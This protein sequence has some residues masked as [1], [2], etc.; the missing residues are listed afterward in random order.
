M[1]NICIVVMYTDNY[2]KMASITVEN[3]I[4]LY[5]NLHNYGLYIDQYK[6]V[7]S[8]RSF[9]WHK[10]KLCKELLLT[11]KYEWLF[12]LDIDCLIMNSSIRLESFIDE[13]YSYILPSHCMPAQDTPITTV[14]GVQNIISSQ[15]FVRNNE[16][17]IAILNAIWDANNGIDINEFDHEGRATRIVINSEQFKDDIKIIEEH[18]LNRFW[19]FNNP[20][21]LNHFKGINDHVWQPGDFIVH[22]TGYPVDERTK[23]LSDLNYFSDIHISK[24]DRAYIL[25]ANDKYFDIVTMC[26]R[27]IRQSSDVHIIIYMLNSNKIVDVPNSTTIN[28][29]CNIGEND[30]KMYSEDENFYIEREHDNIYN[31]LI[32]RPSITKDALQKYANT[33]VYVDSDIIVTQYIDTIFDMYDVNTPYPFVTEGV[34]DYVHI[35]DRGGAESRDDLSTTLEHPACEYFGVNQYIRE[36]Y[37]TTNLYIAGQ[38]SIPFIEEWENMCNDPIIVEKHAW[39][40]PYHE[41]TLMN[42]LLWKY[43]YLIGLPYLYVNGGLEEM[44]HIEAIGF[45]G[46][47]E[48]LSTWIGIPKRKEELL[49]YHGEKRL[50]RLEKML[51]RVNKKK[52]ILF[53]A[54]HLSTGGMPAFL[55][56]R[57]EALMLLNQYE[58]FVIEYQFYCSD[59]VV[60]REQIIKLIGKSHFITLGEH[61]KYLNRALIDLQPDIVHID[62]MSERLDSEMVE[63]LYSEDRKYRIVETCHDISFKPEEKIYVPDAYA[64]C[65]PYHIDTFVDNIGNKTVIE[66]PIEN[67]LTTK[68]EKVK[69]RKLLGISQKGKHVIN[70][71]LWTLGKNQGEGLDIACMF[72]DVTFHFIGNQAGNFSAYWSPYM[73]R[74]PDN[75]IV[76]GERADTD[77]F[78]KAADV[79]MF[80][81]TW[82]CNPLVLR[83]AIGYGLPI[84]ARNLPQYK[85]MFTK[86][87]TPLNMHTVLS[88]LTEML[89]RPKKY[90][91]PVNNTIKDFATA[92]QTLYENLMKKEIPNFKQH[93]PSYKITQHFVGQPFL[94]I[95]GTSKSLF[96]VEFYDVDTRKLIHQTNIACNHWV[97]VNREYYTKYLVKVYKDAELVYSNTLDFK[98]KRV[99]IAFDSQSLGDTIAWIP[100]VEEFRK[101]HDCKVIVSTYK[102]FLFKDVYPELEFVEPDTIVHNLYAM[103]KLGWFYNSDKEP[104]LPNTIPLQQTATNI[105]GLEYEEIRPKIILP[106][107]NHKHTKQVSIATNSTSGCKFWTRENWQEV[108]SYLHNQGY[109]V[110]NTSLEDNP[111]ENCITLHDKSLE[112]TMYEIYNSEFFIGLSSGLSWLAWALDKEVIMIS[113]FTNEEHEFKC[114]RPVVKSVCNSCWNNPNFKF[115]KGDFN[116]CPIHKNTEKHFECQKS[117]TAEMIIDE[118]NKLITK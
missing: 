10:I 69:A 2:S 9:Q 7:D 43:N 90:T 48:Y 47:K 73:D 110:I 67:T 31:I 74:I 107:V 52:R 26:A 36:R 5:C 117:I 55:L 84:L 93:N 100:Y 118:V 32:Q 28:W 17:G 59:F 106:K 75:V 35:G 62:E 21:M 22:V 23:L 25:Y 111:F 16:K 11:N 34:H 97:K 87:I 19:Y 80:N 112:N 13:N 30:D 68:E 114:H 99:Y 54:P 95:T 76:W 92:H 83:E 3:N 39:Y 96:N 109:V 91:I 15:F 14:D 115:D 88:T 63:L 108:I 45:S 53:L 41:E 101:K 20:Y 105:L 40:A 51:A 66:F 79:F 60:Q 33:V 85:N 64:F 6:T 24:K 8:S 103:Y 58:I 37:R 61:K 57:I 77:T 38:A 27:S 98:D 72:P 1:K 29:K 82:E 71:G 86:Y 18:L 65:S 56:K 94:E 49:A 116:W 4:K 70:I 46:K 44:E 12:F 78:F 81:S 42:V 102:N 50:D 89:K 113:N 104:V